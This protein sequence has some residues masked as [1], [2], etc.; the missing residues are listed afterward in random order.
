[1]AGKIWRIFHNVDVS[2]HSFM[3]KGS[4]E[5]SRTGYSGSEAQLSSGTYSL[6]ELHICF[7]RVAIMV[8]IFLKRVSPPFTEYFTIVGNYSELIFLG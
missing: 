2:S 3:D 6:Q 8:D 1:M 4:L 7:S 5:T